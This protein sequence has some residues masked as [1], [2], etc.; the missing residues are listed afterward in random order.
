MSI[1]TYLLGEHGILYALLDWVEELAPQAPLEALRAYRDLMAEGIRSH[2]QME[3][4]L[5]FEPLERATP[6]AESAVRGMRTMHDDIDQALGE[7][8]HIGEPA[9]A[10]QQ[11]LNLMALTKQHFFAEEETV[12]PMAEEEL[13]SA[14]LEDLGRQYLQHRGLLGMGTHV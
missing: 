3:E 5:L 8:A 7:L 1:V 6:R 10:S 14:A 11:L 13:A 9:R 4:E 2:A 12:F